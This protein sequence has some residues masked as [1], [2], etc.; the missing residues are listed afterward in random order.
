MSDRNSRSCLFLIADDWSPIAGCY[1][2]EVVRMPNVD[3]LAERGVVFDH[4]FCTTPSCAASRAV[5]LT[6]HHSHTH[7]MYGLSH[8]IH[9]F[10]CH[11]WMTS[12]PKLLKEAG[13]V[14]ACVGKSHVCP[15]SVFP[16]EYQ[17]KVAGRNPYSMAEGIAQVLSHAADRPFYVHVG[18]YDP[19][20]TTGQRNFGNDETYAGVEEVEY[21]P[22]EV[23]V[24]DFLPDI[25]EVR[26]EL[27]NYYQALS[28]LDKGIG[29]AVQ[30]LEASGRQEETLIIITSDHGMPFPGAKASSF[31]TGHHCPFI[32]LNPQQQNR[33]IHNRALINWTNIAPTVLEWCGV[34]PPAELPERS[35][36][37]ILQETDPQ[38]WDETFFSHCL[39]EITNYYPYR[40]LRGRRYKY[41]RNLAWQ[42]ETPIPADLFRSKTW[43]AVQARGIE[44]LGKRS[45]TRF[46]H[47]D[48]ECLYDLE[49]DPMETTNLLNEPALKEVV[50]EMR[51]KVM[52]FRIRTKDPWLEQSYHEGEIE[53]LR[54]GW[55]L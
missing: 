28:R 15:E 35:L 3:R 6:G 8:G 54:S 14:T 49:N 21:S 47:Q 53:E 1:G 30:A 40:V 9:A 32:I 44:M 11:E 20:R 31:D 45:R 39:H 17:P 13:F 33:G 34:T 16:F 27:A 23:I 12:I 42:L 22:D 19:H 25:P 5:I 46:L 26:D 4:A 18:F 43:Q 24:P 10:R 41:V 52:D 36:L 7:G 37:P 29:L 2:N 50:Q 48:R 38:G 51:E 55:P